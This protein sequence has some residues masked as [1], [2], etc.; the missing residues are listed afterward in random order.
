MNDSHWIVQRAAQF[1]KQRDTILDN[2]QL[3]IT[4]VLASREPSQARACLQKLEDFIGFLST[5]DS[6]QTGHAAPERYLYYVTYAEDKKKFYS[7]IQG[8][9]RCLYVVDAEEKTCTS[10]T[11][12]ADRRRR[13]G[14]RLYSI[15]DQAPPT[16]PRR[17]SSQL[18]H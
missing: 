16:Q 12:E 14:I 5:V 3:Q 6:L 10:W 11:I 15:T 4:E 13:S 18:S 9:W 7:L 8:S 17:G 2:F 1:C